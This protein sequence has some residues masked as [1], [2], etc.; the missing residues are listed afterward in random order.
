MPPTGTV[1]LLRA[2]SVLATQQVAGGV[3]FFSRTSFGGSTA[4][5]RV[6]YSGDATYLPSSG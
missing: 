1:T 4:N 3:A 5:L 2:S 6:T